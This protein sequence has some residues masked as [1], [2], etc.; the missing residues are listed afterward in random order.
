MRRFLI[1]PV[2]L[3]VTTTHDFAPHGRSDLPELG[4]GPFRPSVETSWIS[5]MAVA[6]KIE[7]NCMGVDPHSFFYSP[8]A[9]VGWV[10]TFPS[11]ISKERIIPR[12]SMG[13]GKADSKVQNRMI[14]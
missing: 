14:S 11:Q 8:K 6:V 13:L 3:A 5:I 1:G 10:G 4:P 12:K 2:T 9:G 7:T